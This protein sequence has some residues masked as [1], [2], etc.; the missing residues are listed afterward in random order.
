MA[1]L[2]T[3]YMNIFTTRSTQRVYNSQLTEVVILSMNKQDRC[4]NKQLTCHLLMMIVVLRV[5]LVL[6]EHHQQ[7][8]HATLPA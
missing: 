4:I 1:K 2:N 7:E 3:L 6:S 8:N 5:S